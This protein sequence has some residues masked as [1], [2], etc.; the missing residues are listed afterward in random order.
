M[1]D[2]VAVTRELLEKRAPGQ[3][4]VFHQISDTF[5]VEI[6]DGKVD[7]LHKA[8][9]SGLAVR[10]LTDGRLGFSYTSA[11]D[12]AGL[13]ETVRTAVS[14][15]GHME[16]DSDTDFAGPA[17]MPSLSG[18]IFEVALADFPE[19]DKREMAESIER[20][21]RRQDKRITTVRKSGYA[22]A[23]TTV[24]LVNSL[25]LDESAKAG[26][27]RAWIELMAEE[28][29]E[30][31][32]GFW[33][34][35]ARLPH[36]IDVEAVGITAA[37]RALAGL[38][39]RA[40]P[41]ASIPVVMENT[42]AADLL[43]LLS[44]SF[45]G[46]NHFKDKASP[47]IRVGEKPF[48]EKVTILDDG[49][50]ARGDE[51]FPF[52]GEGSPSCRTV[53]AQNGVVTSLLFDRYHARKFKTATT[54]NC[55]RGSFE[56][57]PAGGITNLSMEPGLRTLKDIVGSIEQG[58]L[59]TDLM[60]LHTANPISGDFSVGASGFR[61]AHG[62]VDHPVKGVAVAGN[63]ID[64]FGKVVDVAD[65]FRYFGNVGAAS[66]LVESLTISGS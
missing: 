62:K 56:S 4:E 64:L 48:S 47:R 13:E 8:R 14:M 15:A 38:G 19:K 59:V 20:T 2:P 28:N 40:V 57:L 12:P 9:L 53:V 63:L 36:D 5:K 33:M 16:A 27:V 26:F 61:I 54:G 18:D 66:F 37:R 23:V 3:W 22:D 11:L 58:L 34:E 46:E 39:G 7:S 1:I 29:G 32:M 55:R 35:Q 65:D 43:R 21:A 41:S 44:H 6:K 51:A 50:D 45:L 25:G 30:Q 17:L 42:V 31:E 10:V 49:L 60:G 24:R 52:D